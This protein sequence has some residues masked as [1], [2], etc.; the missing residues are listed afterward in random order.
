MSAPKWYRTRCSC[1]DGV[2]SCEPSE[3]GRRLS[4]PKLTRTGEDAIVPG[5]RVRTVVFTSIESLVMSRKSLILA[6]A[7]VLLFLGSAGSVLALLV[8]SEPEFYARVGVPPGEYRRR[9][10]ALFTGENSRIAT[11]LFNREDWDARFTEDQINSYFEE[12][13]HKQFPPG[14]GLPESI[15]GVRVCLEDNKIRLGFRYGEGKL[16][17]VLSLD[18]KA[19]LVPKEANVV[20][21]EFLSLHAGALPIS[22]QWLQER[23]NELTRHLNVDPTWY[24][25]DGD[26]VVVLRF[27]ADR[28]EPTFQLQKLELS[29]KLLRITG[30]PIE[31]V[32]P[33]AVPTRNLNPF[34]TDPPPAESAP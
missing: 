34:A 4:D 2:C 24:R 3:T 9:C 15:G 1:R 32:G 13:F 29:D 31:P 33:T 28:S 14:S 25:L 20:A 11:G 12:G 16:S 10:S 30:S 23:V 19:W 7:I 27:Q 22:T 8:R 18:V 5:R 6:I 17:T 26:P 21:V